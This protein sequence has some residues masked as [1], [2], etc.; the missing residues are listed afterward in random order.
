[1]DMPISSFDTLRQLQIEIGV[2]VLVDKSLKNTVVDVR[3]QEDRIILLNEHSST[4][5][6]T[7][8]TLKAL[9]GQHLR[10]STS[11]L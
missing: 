7:R 6:V 10:S 3:R 9:V 1:V 4:A 5:N 8:I 2:G 11:T